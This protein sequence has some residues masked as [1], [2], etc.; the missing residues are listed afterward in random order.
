M[1]MC[2]SFD[3]YLCRY[4]RERSRSLYGGVATFSFLSFDVA[5]ASLIDFLSR[6]ARE[7]SLLCMVMFQST[8]RS[9]C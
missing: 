1:V 2:H 8:G 6:Y 9:P 7:R 5:F 3:W 4:A